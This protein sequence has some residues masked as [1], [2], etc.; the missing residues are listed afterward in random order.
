MEAIVRDSDLDWT[1]IRP[2]GLFDTPEVTDYRTAE[3]YLPGKFTS[4]ADLASSMLA[5]VDSAE[6][7]RKVMA[8]ATVS[9]QPKLLQFFL[10]EAVSK[11]DQQNI[12]VRT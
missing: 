10:K 6:Y 1:I 7:V 3:R 9:A 11:R 5:Q 2:S 8:V 4:R 12:P